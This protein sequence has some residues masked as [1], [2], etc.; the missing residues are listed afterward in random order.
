MV[1]VTTL[2]LI[3]GDHNQLNSLILKV[4]KKANKLRTIH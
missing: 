1:Q 3:N 2:Q 4:K